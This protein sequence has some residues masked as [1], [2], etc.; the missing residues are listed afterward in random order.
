MVKMNDVS[1]ERTGTPRVKPKVLESAK[2]KVPVSQDLL[3]LTC[4]QYTGGSGSY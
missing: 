3:K 1:L 2:R 4:W